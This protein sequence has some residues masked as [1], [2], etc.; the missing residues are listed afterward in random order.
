ML[1]SKSQ[2]C[3]PALEYA[4]I[5]AV[6]QDDAGVQV[7]AASPGIW[8]NQDIHQ[9]EQAVLDDMPSLEFVQFAAHQAQNSLGALGSNVALGFWPQQ[10][11][12][13]I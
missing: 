6:C 11:E 4:I 13:W 5:T 1:V 10:E 3:N 9:Y 12:W 2:H 8:S 7:T